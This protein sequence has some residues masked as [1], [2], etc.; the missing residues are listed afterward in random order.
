MVP[1][2][3]VCKVFI[4]ER[5]SFLINRGMNYDFLSFESSKYEKENHYFN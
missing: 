2:S 1:I 4:P 5:C 3:L